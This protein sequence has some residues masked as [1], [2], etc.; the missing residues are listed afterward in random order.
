MFR[1]S[2]LIKSKP[3][4]LLSWPHWVGLPAWEAW[5]LL[6]QWG[7]PQNFGALVWTRVLQVP[8]SPVLLCAASRN[9]SCSVPRPDVGLYPLFLLTSFGVVPGPGE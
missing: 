6:L 2:Q 3:Q 4:N 8:G 7:P 5:F 9:V 1:C